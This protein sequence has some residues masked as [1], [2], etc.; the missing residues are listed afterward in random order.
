L[1]G[2]NFLK[3]K[4]TAF[5]DQ[6]LIISYK[7]SSDLSILAELYQRYMDLVYGVCMKYLKQHDD[8]QDAV[9]NIYEELIEKVKKH[10]I[11]YFKAWLYQ[12]SKNHC[13]MKL[14]KKKGHLMEINDEF[15]DLQDDSHQELVFI[16]E[17]QLNKMDECIE[18]LKDGQKSSIK[19][20][21][22]ENKCYQEIA[23]ITSTDVLQVKSAIQNG[24]RNL[25]ICME[26]QSQ[27]K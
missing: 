16:K 13:L 10:Q 20:F 8:A 17:Q 21:Y 5:S 6:E 14:R 9:I 3:S 23:A 1:H 11:D 27:F 4:S 15:M 25:K 18:G 24:R 2:V 26:T 12:L 19:L 7:E 22:Y